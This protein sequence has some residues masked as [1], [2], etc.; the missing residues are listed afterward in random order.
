MA[1]EDFMD[2]VNE[3]ILEM[4]HKGFEEYSRQLCLLY[5]DLNLSKLPKELPHED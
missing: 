4:I 3:S 5:L 1:S 2:E